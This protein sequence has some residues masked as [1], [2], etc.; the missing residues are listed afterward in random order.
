MAKINS[1]IT[2]I[3]VGDK[4]YKEMGYSEVCVHMRVAGKVMKAEIV[5][6][7]AVQLHTFNDEDELAEQ[8]FSFPILLGEAGFYEDVEG[9]YYHKSLREAAYEAL[10][11]VAHKDEAEVCD[12]SAKVVDKKLEE[13]AASSGWL[14]QEII[15]EIQVVLGVTGR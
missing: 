7:R 15:N 14:Q 3:K 9:I 11:I 13:L 2:R 8:P 4:I 6:S 1:T 5:S 12:E 10:D